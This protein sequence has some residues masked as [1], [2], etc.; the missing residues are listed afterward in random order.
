[1]SRHIEKDRSTV[2]AWK[3]TTTAAFASLMLLAAGPMYA[4]G[5]ASINQH[6]LVELSEAAAAVGDPNAV[7]AELVQTYGGHSEAPAPGRIHGF[8][9]TMSA[10]EARLLAADPRVKAVRETTAPS[11]PKQAPPRRIIADDVLPPITVGPFKYDGAG[12][13]I[14]MGTDRYTYDEMSRITSG[15]AVTA[16]NGDTQQFT[17]DGFGNLKTVI[18]PNKSTL[19]IDHDS[20]TNRLRDTFGSETAGTNVTHMWGGGYDAAGDQQMANGTPSYNYDSMNMMSELTSPRHEFYIYDADD[21]RVATVGY[22]DSQNS[23]WRYTLRDEGNHVLRTVTDTILAGTDSWQQTEDYV[24]RTGGL[25]A[26]ITPQGSAESR[27]HF[28]LDHLGSPVLVTD[29]NGQRLSSHKYWPFGADAPGTDADGERMKFTGHERDLSAFD[30]NGLD[31]M[32]ARYYSNSLGR[33]LSV[34]PA[35]DLESNIPKPQRWNRYAYVSNNPLGAIDPNGRLQVDANGNVI[36]VKTGSA[37]LPFI[38]P[39]SPQHNGHLISATW[40][41]DVGY[42]L[43]D[44]GHRVEATRATSDIFWED[45][46]AGGTVVSDTAPAGFSD[47]ADCHGWTF[48]KGQVWI[49]NDQ[50]PTILKGDG[51]QKTATPGVGS[52]GIYSNSEGA[53]H[54][55][56]V[57]GVD[58]NGKPNQVDSKGGITAPA[59]LAPGPGPGSAWIAKA[60]LEY[61]DKALKP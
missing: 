44:D 42:V 14:H 52:V 17:Y 10:E 19:Y 22:T 33:F 21:E 25:L 36:F 18:V 3:R 53:Q 32:H 37:E 39:N 30:P 49:N 31:Y 48:A 20:L 7:A 1:M 5:P 13:I 56:T 4:E 45:R 58:T 35:M 12:N 24:Y 61:Y 47:V 54:S 11:A 41:A 26:A 43:T 34:D 29:D 9:I 15:T 40:Q 2:T 23:V 27:K 60:L 57:T 6:Y 38:D 46:N 55:V 51:Y 8:A 50:V 59:L 16:Q 28:H